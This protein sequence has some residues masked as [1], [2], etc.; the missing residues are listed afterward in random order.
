MRTVIAM[1]TLIR[2]AFARQ[3]ASPL[4]H[5]HV[6]SQ[7]RGLPLMGEGRDEGYNNIFNYRVLAAIF[8]FSIFAFVENSYNQ[9]FLPNNSISLDTTGSNKD[10]TSPVV[11]YSIVADSMVKVKKMQDSMQTQKKQGGLTKP[12]PAFD[13]A[14][15]FLTHPY[16]SIGIGWGLGSFPLLSDW[17]GA[18]P[19]SAGTI[20]PLNPDTLG[21]KVTEPVNTYNIL[22]PVYL[23]FTPFVYRKS[24]V[25]F[26]GSFFFIG[27]SQ[28][29]T[30]QHDTLPAKIDYKQSMNCFGFSAGA[31]YR[32]QI[33]ERYF[34]I[35]KVDRTSFIFGLSVL[36]Y[37]HL[38]K[39][40]SISSSGINDSVVFAAH[41][42]LQN[43]HAWGMGGSWRIGI[44]SQQ[45]LSATSGIEISLS[46]IGR[47]MGVFRENNTYLLNKDINPSADNPASK[48][49]SL[50]NTVEIRLEFLSGK[51]YKAESK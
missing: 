27:K 13:S 1:F 12:V 38:S 25:A 34:K 32:H 45:T 15:R 51:R 4:L 6:R 50:S 5:V 20:L 28:Q 3:L 21:F 33:D 44:C 7:S 10:T 47:Y 49:S 29:A 43:F 2:L 19:D 40:E 31:F 26:E 8:F 17:Q 22:F 48:L 36:P 23:S 14:S 11:P 46:Y 42:R 41:G 16:F 24:S 35:D 37:L 18:L 9:T 39:N 30:L